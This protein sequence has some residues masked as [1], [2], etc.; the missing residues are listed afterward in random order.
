ML[1]W[2]I[3]FALL[4][5]VTAAVTVLSSPTELSV[6]GDVNGGC[7]AV[8]YGDV[9]EFLAGGE[10]LLPVEGDLFCSEEPFSF[11]LRVAGLFAAVSIP[12]TKVEV[13]SHFRPY[14]LKEVDGKLIVAVDPPIPLLL[15]LFLPFVFFFFWRRR[16]RETMDEYSEIINYLSENPGSTQKQI[17]RALGMPEYKVSRLLSRLEKEGVVVRVR[18]GMSKRVY[19][20]E[21]LQG[22]AR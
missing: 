8:L 7:V 20:A 11:K 15:L 16:R 14:E 5:V 4:P 13:I 17:A 6:Y 22:V 10:K 3:L 21:Q 12:S 2:L 19:L 9:K 18:R 1:R